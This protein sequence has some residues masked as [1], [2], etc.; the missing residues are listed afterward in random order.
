MHP[1]D[2]LD[3]LRNEIGAW[4]TF[5]NGDRDAAIRILQPV[6][7]RQRKVGKG[8]VELPAG[9]MLAEIL[10]LDGRAAD[11]LQA[12]QTSLSSDPNRFNALLGAGRAAE[13]SGQPALA[14]RYYG[15]LLANCEGATGAAVKTLERLRSATP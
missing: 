10:L 12:Y 11:A 4:A 15:T 7:D 5:S 13:L 8:E 3:T 2:G 6:A 9:E 1:G 14:A